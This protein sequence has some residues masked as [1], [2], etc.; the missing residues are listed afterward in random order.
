MFSFFVLFTKE[1]PIFKLFVRVTV[2]LIFA[3]LEKLIK[4]K[5]SRESWKTFKKIFSF[6][7]FS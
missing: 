5:T 7:K 6:N 2:V 4:V 3:S 1:Y